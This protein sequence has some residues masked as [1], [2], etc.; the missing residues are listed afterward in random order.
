MRE[1]LVTAVRAFILTPIVLLSVSIVGAEVMQSGNYRIQSDSINFGGGL[2]T[3][4][5]YSLE[6][7]AGES[8]TGEATSASY[9]LRAGYQQMQESYISLSGF[10][11][12][13]LS[14]SIPGI[15]GGFSN[16]STAV[17]VVTDSVSGYMLE[18][19]GSQSPAMQKGSDTI[20]DYAPAGAAPDYAF[21]TNAADAHFG[22]SPEGVDIVARFKDNGAAC[23]AGS[24]DTLLACWDGLNTS[25][26]TVARRT[27]ANNPNGSTTTLNFRVGVGGSVVQPPGAY[28]ATTTLT[29]LTL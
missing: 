1:L 24:D 3:S 29:A 13:A 18:I 6:S 10:G 15:S 17:L 14:P 16:G 21:T 26:E 20:A 22:Y 19:A 7:T 27:S 8:G 2:A 11:T 28:T 25:G 23:N 4:T 12:V 9:E 5:N